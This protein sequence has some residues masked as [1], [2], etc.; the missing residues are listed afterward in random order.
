VSVNIP[1]A[2]AEETVR[3]TASRFVRGSVV[4]LP[5]VHDLTSAGLVTRMIALAREDRIVA[6][7]G[8]SAA[9]YDNAAISKAHNDHLTNIPL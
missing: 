8:D 4:R 3:A 5:V 9:P 2:A 7:V 6:F 1:C